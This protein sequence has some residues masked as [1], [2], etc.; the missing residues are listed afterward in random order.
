MGPV[1]SATSWLHAAA[2]SRRSVPTASS[3][4]R[5]PPSSAF[6]PA[7]RNSPRRKS[8]RSPKRLIAGQSIRLAPSAARLASS[9]LFLAP[10]EWVST[11]VMSGAGAAAYR[12]SSAATSLLASCTD[13]MMTRPPPPAAPPPAERLEPVSPGEGAFVI[14]VPGHDVRVPAADHRSPVGRAQG[15]G[16]ADSRRAKRLGDAHAEM[17]DRQGDDERHRR[18]P[19]AAGRVIRPEGDRHALVE[20]RADRREPPRRHGRGGGG[21]R[22]PPPPRPGGAGLLAPAPPPGGRLAAP[23]PPPPR[24]PRAGG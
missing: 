22:R 8:S 6:L 10:P 5:R 2:S 1:V 3:S 20:Q 24:P 23:F 15:V 4:A 14:G 9:G 19:D 11:S 16:A 18:D 7:R 12:L 13:L 17:G 21:P